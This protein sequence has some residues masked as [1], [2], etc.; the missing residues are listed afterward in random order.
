MFAVPVSSRTHCF[1]YQTASLL[2][3]ILTAIHADFRH[4]SGASVP[5]FHYHSIT[6]MTYSAFEYKLTSTLCRIAPRK[7]VNQTPV[8]LGGCRA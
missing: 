1:T 8:M 6:V 2:R 3:T 7:E 5:G 4:T